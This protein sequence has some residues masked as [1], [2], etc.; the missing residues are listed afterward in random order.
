MRCLKIFLGLS[1]V[2]LARCSLLEMS[3]TM[4]AK[5]LAGGLSKVGQLDP[6]KVPMVKVDQSEGNTNYRMILRNV[7]ISGLNDSTVESIQVARGK[8][9]SNLSELE[10]GY[11]TYSDIGDLE[12]IRY[13]FHTVLN[14]LRKQNGNA[15]ANAGGSN[16]SRLTENRFERI[17][18]YEPRATSVQNERIIQNSGE[19]NYRSYNQRARFQERRYQ[20]P[21][22][23]TTEA[24]TDS[25][26]MRN[27]KIEERMESSQ[28][29]DARYPSSVHVIYAQNSKSSGNDQEASQKDQD[30]PDCPGNCHPRQRSSQSSVDRASMK[31]S[32]SRQSHQRPGDVERFLAQAEDA[33]AS[34]SENKE[35]QF[36][37]QSQRSSSASLM[38]QRSEHQQSSVEGQIERMSQRSES[39]KSSDQR[40]EKKPG[41][42]DIVYADRKDSGRVKHFGNMRLLV[43]QEAKV[44]GLDEVMKDIREDKQILLLN[45]TE[46]ES[47]TKKNERVRSGLESK[48][49]E[50]LSRYADNYQEKE[51]YFEEGMELI[52]HYGGMGNDTGVKNVRRIKRAHLEND[53]EA[54]DVMHVIMRI[55]VPLLRVK[56]EYMLTGKVG[57]EVLRGNGLLVGNFTELRG[58]FTVELKKGKED[59]MIVRATRAKLTTKDKSIDLQGMDE[60]GPVKSILAQGLMAAEAVAAMLADDLATKALS[61]KTADAMVYRMYNNLPATN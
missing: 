1:L 28:A 52:Y 14:N 51:G 40:L 46:G 2:I 21:Q 26:Y 12:S 16:S 32:S 48:S 37:Q 58:D 10:A 41:Y 19:S 23:T 17:T 54:D 18:Q 6:L 38:A 47:L 50:D 11:V 15:D 3:Q 61:E 44:Y 60:E 30:E 4:W 57:D 34:A 36:Q 20:E 29:D 39:I 8:L 27:L 25:S 9:R 24:R 53:T 42:I 33:Y 13:K 45:F 22:E 56:S 59:S 35:T 31:Q 55:R 49:L 5:L 7:E 43:N